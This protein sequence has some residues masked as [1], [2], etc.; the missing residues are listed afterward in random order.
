M[1]TK[2]IFTIAEALPHLVADSDSAMNALQA[3]IQTELPFRIRK[4]GGRWSRNPAV[5]AAGECCGETRNIC[6]YCI[7]P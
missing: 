4:R 3:I 6:V 2:R 7:V 5:C 1:A